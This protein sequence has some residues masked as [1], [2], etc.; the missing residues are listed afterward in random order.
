MLLD[1][2]GFVA[3]DHVRHEIVGALRATST[4][5]NLFADA[6]LLKKDCPLVSG[7]KV[8]VGFADAWAEIAAIFQILLDRARAANPPYKVTFA[9]YSLGGATA[10]LAAA[11][12]RGAGYEGVDLY[13]YGSPRVGNDAFVNY[14]MNQKGN[15]YRVTHFEDLA[16]TYVPL[17]LGYRHTFPEF[18]LSEGPSTRTSYDLQEVQVCQGTTQR[19]C[20]SAKY[21]LDFLSHLYYFQYTLRCLPISV[22]DDDPLQLLQLATNASFV[23]RMQTWYTKDREVEARLGV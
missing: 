19:E 16:P 8:H 1:L 7:C 6:I 20:N 11:H 13:T 15:E 14:V 21:N 10:T 22:R 3:V 12:L 2:N 5:R 23:E 18:W 9:G 4:L 17:F